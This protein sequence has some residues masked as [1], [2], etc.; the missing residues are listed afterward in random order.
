ME[1]LLLTTEH[2]EDNYGYEDYGEAYDDSIT[3]VGWLGQA[4]TQQIKK[5]QLKGTRCGRT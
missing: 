4:L 5:K 1:Q 3:L 2:A